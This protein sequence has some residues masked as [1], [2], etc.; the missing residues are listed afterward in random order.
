MKLTSKYLL[1]M[2]LSIFAA[3]VFSITLIMLPLNRFQHDNIDRLLQEKSRTIEVYLQKQL[4]DLQ[5]KNI[6]Y[7]YW[8]DTLDAIGRRDTAWL[9]TNISQYLF[10]SPFDIDAVYLQLNDDPL[11]Q[12]YSDELTTQ[13]IYQVLSSV[14]VLASPAATFLRLLNN[15]LYMFSVAPISNNDGTHPAV[16][17]LLLGRKMDE[18]FLLPL[19]DYLGDSTSINLAFVEVSNAYHTINEDSISFI[20]NF[21]DEK[22]QYLAS[23]KVTLDISATNQLKSRLFLNISFLVFVSVILC[24]AGIH[25]F[26][27]DFTKRF[28]NVVE[29]IKL[30][31][32]GNYTQKLPLLGESEIQ[33]LSLS[34]NQLSDSILTKI[35]Q[36]QKSYLQT[37]EALVT[38]IEVK[39]P[40]TKGH[41]ERVAKYSLLISNYLHIDNAGIIETAALIHDIGK[42]GIPESILNKPGRLT[43]DEFSYIKQHPEIG[44]KILDMIEEFH[45]IKHIIRHHHEWFNGQG[46]PLGLS[47]EAIPLGARVIAVADAF[48]AMTSSRP[49]KPPSSASEALEEIRRMSGKQFD[50]SVV[51]AFLAVMNPSLQGVSQTVLNE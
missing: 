25:Y 35:S 23:Y 14:P 37:I 36:L 18:D 47:G 19:A 34:V 28:N 16:G 49:Y 40:Y 30:I 21:F 4:I 45:E 3:G 46:Y 2:I 13:Q 41:S 10:E 12:I 50:P 51:N 39:D 6:E 20:H 8:D 26:S 31:A 32:A 42:I 29:G 44:Y 48:D 5:E 38:T 15:E 27:R 43:E 9:M 24:T 1:G 33:S 7:A 11:S 22:K 17:S